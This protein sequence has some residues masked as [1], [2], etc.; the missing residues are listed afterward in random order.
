MYVKKSTLYY[1]LVDVTTFVKKDKFYLLNFCFTEHPKGGVA[2]GQDLEIVAGDQDP[3][4]DIGDL[5]S[6][7]KLLYNRIWIKAVK[8]F[9]VSYS[10]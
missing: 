6:Y 10:M 4:I 2:Q 8:Y 1:I 3:E 9:F 7:I 5:G